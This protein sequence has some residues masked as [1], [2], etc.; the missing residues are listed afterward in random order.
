VITSRSAETSDKYY[1]IALA[2]CVGGYYV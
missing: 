2:A 1:S